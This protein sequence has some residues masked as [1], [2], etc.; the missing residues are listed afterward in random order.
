MTNRTDALGIKRAPSGFRWPG[1]RNVAVVFNVAYEV[2]SEGEVS[3]VGPM[4]NPLPAGKFD[5]N[6]DSYG[7][8]GANAG[9]RRLVRVLG[10]AGVS[11]SIY[12]SGAL[13]ERDPA[14]VKALADAGHE[15]VAHGYAQD[16]IPAAL[17]PEDDER[18]IRRTTELLESVTGVRPAGWISPRA[19]AGIDTVQRL[20]RWGYVW[21]GDVLDDDLP[22]LQEFDAGSIV[23]V[24]LSIEFNDLSHAMRFGRTPREFVDSFDE[25][26][27]HAIANEDDVVMLDVL[28]HSHC[29]GRP[30]GAWAYA[31]IARKCAAR[32]D[33]WVATRAEIAGHFLATSAP[34]SG[35]RAGMPIGKVRASG[36]V[37]T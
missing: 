28:V 10:E 4:G 27:E 17:S 30:A 25:A 24:P 3:G 26:L 15:I 5:P 32:E 36:G 20:V 18:Y 9:I 8:Y 35:Y 1:G 37:R 14:Q 29:Y 16:L 21:H 22:Y 2:W 7:R 34:S 19:T 33:I 13:A 12:T 23:A 31:E 11:A 6:A